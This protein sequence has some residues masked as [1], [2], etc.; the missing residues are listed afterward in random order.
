M[1][2]PSNC[3]ARST[4]ASAAFGD[5]ALGTY[6]GTAAHNEADGTPTFLNA[7][8]NTPTIPVGPSYDDRCSPSERMTSASCAVPTTDTGRV[9]GTSDNNAPSEITSRTS[10]SAATS[11]TCCANVRHR[12]CGSVPMRK[13]TSRSA[14]GSSAAEN[15][16]D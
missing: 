5:G 16:V 2:T 6:V 14:P 12:N 7:S 13:T 10:S 9:C 11:T 1:P 3:V 8:C 15:V 4:S